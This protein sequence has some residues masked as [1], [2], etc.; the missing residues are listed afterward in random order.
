MKI[1]CLMPVVFQLLSPWHYT[2][3]AGN[4]SILPIGCSASYI[5]W[6]D[7]AEE[8]ATSHYPNAEK[9]DFL[10]VG[11]KPQS[12]TTK[13]HVY[14]YWIR[15]RSHQ[16]GV[17]VSILIDTKSNKMLRSTVEETDVLIPSYGKWRN[18]AVKSMKMK[19]PNATIVDYSPCRC[20]VIDAGNGSQTFKFWILQDSKSKF[21]NTTINYHMN[22]EKVNSVT[23]EEIT[24]N[25]K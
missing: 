22:T 12:L 14:K 2:D 13:N 9:I 10:Y 24:I 6:V 4:P 5:E 11:C 7:E 17:Y 16:F 8:Q 19:Y 21:I 18:L 25:P 3:T 20:D 15:D 1:I 23:F